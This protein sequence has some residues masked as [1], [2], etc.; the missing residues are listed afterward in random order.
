MNSQS[1]SL[2]LFDRLNTTCRLLMGLYLVIVAVLDAAAQTSVIAWGDNSRGQS[3]VP[4][5]LGEVVAVAAGHEH[6]LALKADGTVASW[7]DNY[8]GQRGFPAALAGV[9]AIAAGTYHFCRKVGRH[10]AV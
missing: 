1:P 6:S 9:V 2:Y 10:Y 7:G 5:G 3:T 8:Y 4:A